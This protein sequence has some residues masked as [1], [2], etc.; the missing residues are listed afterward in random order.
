MRPKERSPWDEATTP[1][2]PTEYPIADTSTV[3]DPDDPIDAVLLAMHRLSRR[4]R[5]DYAV[6]GNPFGNFEGMARR[7]GLPGF[8]P[9]EA[10]E[11]MIAVKEERLMALRTN[12]RAPANEAVVDS[13]IDRAVYAVLAVAYHQREHQGEPAKAG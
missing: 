10:I 4:K 5:A 1:E 6:D 7:L 11:V 9:A 13:L 3:L 12:D 8:T 2:V